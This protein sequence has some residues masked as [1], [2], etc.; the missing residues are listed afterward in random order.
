MCSVHKK[1][2]DVYFWLI[3][4]LEMPQNWIHF[5]QAV[6]RTFSLFKS[7]RIQESSLFF[8][9][10][11][12]HRHTQRD[13]EKKILLN[14]AKIISVTSAYVSDTLKCM[15][16][17]LCFLEKKTT[18]CH[19]FPDD[20]MCNQ[21]HRTQIFLKKWWMFIVVLLNPSLII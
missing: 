13:G 9:H 1:K 2:R 11:D 15:E 7:K 5:H 14:N 10:R 19:L 6:L 4:P 12:I 20:T 18:G 3:A 8:T 17:P 16:M 21:N